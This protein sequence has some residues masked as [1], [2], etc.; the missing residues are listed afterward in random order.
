M[1]RLRVRFSINKG[2]RGA[3][4]TKLGRIAEQ[5]EKFLRALAVDCDIPSKP[6]EWLAANFKNGSVEYDAELPDDVNPG[7]AQI[8][9]RY[10]EA[11]ADFDPDG[12]GLNI[13]VSDSTAIEYARIGTIIDPDENIGLGIYPVR[14][15][16]PKWRSISYSSTSA[17]RR[18]I[19]TPI[20]AYGSVQGI[21]HAWFKEAREP[22]FQLRELATETL[23]RVL[24]PAS[25]YNRVADAVRER[26]TM[27][28][29]SGNML[30]DRAT[31]QAT[32]LRA[33]RIDKLEMLSTA[34]FESFFGSAPHFDAMLDEGNE[35]YLNG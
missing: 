22:N 9:S 12:D 35:T 19:E 21:L 2:R 23:V 1:A 4:M 27:L 18:N 31:R 13:G 6:G 14:G 11:L 16:R 10:L 25:L 24:Y 17:I 33:E 15:G 32:E 29:V 7:S 3:P 28:M 30:F 26:T 8:F 5:A 20:P 34:E